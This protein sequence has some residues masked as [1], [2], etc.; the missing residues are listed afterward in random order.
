MS[1]QAR[2]HLGLHF[3]TYQED[4]QW[5]SECTELGVGS[6]GDTLEEATRNI[7]DAT[8]LYLQVLQDEGQLAQVLRE[9]GLQVEFGQAPDEPRIDEWIGRGEIPI[10]AEIG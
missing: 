1:E 7:V 3:R 9:Q 6:C 2:G 10:P 5:T 4:G 8:V